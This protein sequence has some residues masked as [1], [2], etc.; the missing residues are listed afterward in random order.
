MRHL[1]LRIAAVV[2]AITLSLTSAAAQSGARTV[3]TAWAQAMQANDVD[4]VT[5]LYAPDAVAWFPDRP[6]ARGSAAIRDGYQALLSANTVVAASISDSHYRT[7]GKSSVGWGKFSMT[8]RPKAG[9][10]VV[11][12]TGR[13][14]EVAERRG[15]RWVY[16]VD[17]ASTEPAMPTAVK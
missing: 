3:D 16:L 14:T 11:T 6:E 1:S 4:A 13:F 12:M 5:G 17:H 15:G 9:G 2:A 8:L 10:N 7:V